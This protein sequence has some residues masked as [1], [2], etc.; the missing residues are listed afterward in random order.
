MC[1]CWKK[2]TWCLLFSVNVD[3]LVF[4]KLNTTLKIKLS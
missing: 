1:D 3:L 2:K 4:M